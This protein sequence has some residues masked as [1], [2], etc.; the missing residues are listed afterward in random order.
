MMTTEK[1]PYLAGTYEL[2]I[3]RDP[4]GDP[5]DLVITVWAVART[6]ADEQDAPPWM[7]ARVGVIREEY[8]ELPPLRLLGR[9]V[10][11]KKAV[12][13]PEDIEELYGARLAARIL[14]ALFQAA[15][16][17]FWGRDMYDN[18]VREERKGAF[19]F[20]ER[21]HDTLAILMAKVYP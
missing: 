3:E 12:L 4:E 11:G 21:A 2:L 5:G 19:P 16:R 17:D 8:D 6:W 7:L 20:M 15:E 1:N 13:Q 10:I 14:L 18:T 9:Q